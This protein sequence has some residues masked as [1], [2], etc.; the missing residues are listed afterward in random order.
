MDDKIHKKIKQEKR[1]SKDNHQ[2]TIIKQT[3][4]KPRSNG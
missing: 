3:H 1:C 4:K 2:I